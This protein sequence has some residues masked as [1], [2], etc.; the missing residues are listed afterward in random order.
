[1]IEPGVA[2]CRWCMTPF[3]GGPKV[4]EM[5]A[6]HYELDYDGCSAKAGEAAALDL[7]GPVRVALSPQAARSEDRVPATRLAGPLV[8]EF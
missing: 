5:V 3:V 7:L 6:M 1:M 8:E 2:V 4:A